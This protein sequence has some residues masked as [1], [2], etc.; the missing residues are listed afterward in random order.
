MTEEVIISSDNFEDIKK[1]IINGGVEN[2]HVL[3]DFDRTLT[4]AFYKG[5]KA[6][7]KKEAN[8]IAYSHG[9]TADNSQSSAP[10][11]VN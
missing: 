3:A 5:E 10:L 9:N 1:A 11:T 6:S 8:H 2:F 7:L 4:K